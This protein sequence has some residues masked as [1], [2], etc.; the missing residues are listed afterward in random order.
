YNS[1]IEPSIELVKGH[2]Y[3]LSFDILTNTAIGVYWYGNTG[4]GTYS[5]GRIPDTK[6]EWIKHEF[7]YTQTRD[8]FKGRFLFGFHNLIA[9]SEVKYRNL[10]L[11]KGNVATDWTPAPE[12]LY[13]QEEFKIFNAQYTQDVTGM[14]GRL[15]T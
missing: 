11:E 13:T 12:D 8:S 9:G 6:G 10:K 5:G 4:G 15:T 1:M 3:T 14:T 7:T 2:E